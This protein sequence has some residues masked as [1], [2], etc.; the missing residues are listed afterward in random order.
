MVNTRLAPCRDSLRRARLLPLA[1]ILAASL[2]LAPV[3]AAGQQHFQSPEAGLKS[4]IDAVKAN[5]RDRLL[6]IFGHDADDLVFSGDEVADREAMAHFVRETKQRTNLVKVDEATVIIQFGKDDAS[7][8]IPLVK[9]G[10]GWRFDTAAGKEEMLNRRIGRNELQAIAVCH[11][12]V[13]AQREYASKDRNGTGVRE[14]A[15]KF[16]SAPGKQDGLYWEVSANE[17]QSPMGPWVAMAT[18]EGYAHKGPDTEPMPFHG[19]FFRILTAQG[20][21]APEG[22]RSYIADGHMTG[23]FALVAYPAQ[24]GSGGVMTFMVNQLGIVFQKDLGNKTAEIAAAMTQYD[25]DDSW[26]PVEE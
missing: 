20:P 21:H 8:P 25:P 23:G 15:Q 10:S 4:L 9:D 3:R 24:H 12:Y 22:A 17:A 13:D 14:Y 26:H 18:S 19:Y 11:A 7:F 6:A 16:R 2:V 5:D 1:A